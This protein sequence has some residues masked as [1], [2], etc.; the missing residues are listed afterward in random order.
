VKAAVNQT[1]TTTN[2]STVIN[3]STL[4]KDLQYNDKDNPMHKDLVNRLAHTLDF[5]QT[6]YPDQGLEFYMEK[7][8]EQ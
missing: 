4:Q 6:Q 7:I 1:I 3:A 8:S 5:L 2:T